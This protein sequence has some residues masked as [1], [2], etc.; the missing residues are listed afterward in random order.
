MMV[1]VDHFKE[2]NDTFGHGG[3]DVALKAVA[4]TLSRT[5]PRR[6]DLVAR[7]GGDE[8]AVVLRGL[9]VDEARLLAERLVTS[10]RSTVT[11]H[12]GRPM[13]L[14][15]SVGSPRAATETHRELRSL[16]QT[17]PSTQ[18]RRRGETAGQS[19]SSSLPWSPL[20]HW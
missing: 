7:Y 19:A 6:G 9:R 4:D 15:V 8:F 17:Q 2:A 1:D 10:V 18:R 12:A 14:T 16:G 3:G 5:F 20:A 11:T 13:K